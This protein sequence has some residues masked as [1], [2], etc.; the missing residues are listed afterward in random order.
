MKVQFRLD[1]Y[2]VAEDGGE[3]Q[4]LVKNFY[5]EAGLDVSI[6]PG[7]PAAFGI[8]EVAAG[9]VQFSMG[10]CDN[11]I[12]AV[13]QGAP[14]VIVAAHM[15]HNPQSIMVH[16][17]SPVRSFRDL[18][19]KSVMCVVG[20]NWIDYLQLQYGIHLNVIPMD[21]GLARFMADK[22]FVQQCYITSEPYYVEMHGVKARAMLISTA[23]YDPYRAIFTTK[24]FA[25]EHPEAVKA[26]VSGTIR[27]WSDFLAGDTTE[28]RARIQAENSSQSPALMDY[29]VATLK[30]YKLV[31]GDPAKGD[32]IG[33]ITPERM[34]ALL[35][36][37]VE[38]KILDA[39]LPLEDFVSFDF[40]PADFKSGKI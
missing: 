36:T 25:R 3:Y 26:F 39:P 35:R 19:G 15:E 13:H 11:V 23:G 5:R 10:P 4:A 40:L 9:H 27:G 17:E 34:T 7:G 2:P 28:A 12:M 18:D 1:W 8:Q 14:L 30:R 37:L 31:G 24:A 16:D 22:N 32:R 6:L 38:L 29:T 33:L 20:S 21:Y